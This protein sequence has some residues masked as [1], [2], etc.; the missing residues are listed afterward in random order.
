M[1]NIKFQYIYPA[2]TINGQDGRG[3]LGSDHCG[4]REGCGPAN[5][6]GSLLAGRKPSLPRVP[7]HVKQPVRCPS[8]RVFVPSA[9]LWWFL[10]TSQ[11][12]PPAPRRWYGPCRVGALC[13]RAAQIPSHGAARNGNRA[14]NKSEG[15]H[16]EGIKHLPLL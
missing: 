12:R 10:Q 2:V 5:S 11:R 3:L 7:V 13:G 8:R 9:C 15:F 16:L 4:Q 14:T 1:G 6:L